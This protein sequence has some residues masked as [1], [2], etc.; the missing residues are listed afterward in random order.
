[1]T[2]S[3][4]NISTAFSGSK[5]GS[6]VRHAPA[7]MAE[8]SPHGLPEGVE[9]RQRAE[10]DVLLGGLGERL[11]VDLGVLLEVAVGEL[12]ALGRARGAAG[13]EDHGGVVGVDVRDVVV[14]LGGAEQLLELAR[15]DRD[16]L[17]AGLLGA[18][19]GGLREVVPGEQDLRARVLEVERDLA[20]LEQDV[21]RDDD[22]ARAQDPVVDDREVRDVREH[23]PDAVAALEALLL[24]QVRDPRGPLVEQGVVDDRVVELE[25]R[26]VAE[27]L[28]RLGH[29]ARQVLA[30]SVLSPGVHNADVPRLCIPRRATRQTPCWARS[31]Q[32]RTSSTT[33]RSPRTVGRAP[34]RDDVAAEHQARRSRRLIDT[35]AS[36][37]SSGG[38]AETVMP[39]PSRALRYQVSGRSPVISCASVKRSPLVHDGWTA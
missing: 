9:Q 23:D 12:G 25:R 14:G 24:E 33:R 6:S 27:L 37:P 29:E 13:V 38:E 21:H 22:A 19:L 15:L 2:L 30:H 4:S 18:G 31:I 35:V 34:R 26:P 3:R 10:D 17:G 28:G 5:R 7:W 32:A 39:A 36:T 8:L 20:A 11:D 1:M 16:Q